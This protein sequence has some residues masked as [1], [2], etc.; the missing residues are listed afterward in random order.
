MASDNLLVLQSLPRFRGNLKPHE[1]HS[2]VPYL[3]VRTFIRALENHFKVHKIE[4]NEQRL[5]I[6]VAQVD[7]T[8][9]DAINLVNCYAGRDVTFEQVRDDFL[10]M[11]PEFK[12]TEFTHA[13][14][15]IMTTKIDYPTLFCGMTRLENLTRSLTEAYLSRE[16]VKKLK[17]DEKTKINEN[18]NEVSITCRDLL[19]NFAMHLLLATQLEE[20]VYEKISEIDPKIPSTRFMATAVK[21]AEKAKIEKADHKIKNKREN[22]PEQSEVL[23]NIKKIEAPKGCQQCGKNNHNTRDCYANKS[24]SYCKKTGH[25]TKICKKRLTDKVAFCDR[26]QRLNHVSTACKTKQC[27]FCRRFGH[28]YNECRNRLKQ[29]NSQNAPSFK[30]TPNKNEKLNIIHALE[31]PNVEDGENC[32]TDE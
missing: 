12:R 15:S 23:F 18:D 10:S 19:Q 26:C 1:K 4:D 29:N 32:H 30:S 5:R 2:P 11:Y 16:N 3:N 25:T 8:S 7:K 24:C 22:N 17:I 21:F 9:G 20:K 6:L 14:S 13:A 28:S 27:S 31:D